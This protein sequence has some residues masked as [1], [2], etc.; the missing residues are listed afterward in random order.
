M[1]STSDLAFM[2]A[3]QEA[4]MMDECTI[5][6]YT[7]GAANELGLPGV[8]YVSGVAV[9]CGF[10]PVKPEDGVGAADVPMLDAKLR[11]PV[12]TSITPHDRVTVTSRFG[13]AVT[14]VTFEVVGEV[15]RGPSGLWLDLVKVTD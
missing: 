14:S 13:V 3:T 9:K 8:S 1:F 4:H 11:L 10:E 2:Q 6:V 5:D 7:E 15:K 12:S